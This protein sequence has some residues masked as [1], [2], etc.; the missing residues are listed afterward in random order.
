[1]KAMKYT[2]INWHK[3]EKELL[4]L[5]LKI[6]AAYN[7]GDHHRV[8][9]LQETLVRTF[10]ARALAVRRVTT[11]SGGKTPGV[12]GIILK[13]AESK[14]Q[15]IRDIYDWDDYV[16]SPVKQVI[17]PKANGGERAL[18]I[19]T[20]KD[21]VAQCL[22]MF[23]LQ[24]IAE[25]SADVQSYGFR[26]GRSTQD[27]QERLNNILNNKNSPAYVLDA[28]IKGFFD[29]ID[30][31]W[32]LQHIPMNKVILNKWLKAGIL[33]KSGLIKNDGGVPQGGIISPIIANMVLDGLQ[34][35]IEE[36]VKDLN[37]IMKNK[38]NWARVKAKKAG[39]PYVTEPTRTKINYVRYA[40]DFIITAG[41]PQYY[42]IVMPKVSEFLKER[43]LELNKSKTKIFNVKK[44]GFDFLGFHMQMRPSY[45]KSWGNKLE[46]TCTKRGLN[47]IYLKIRTAMKKYNE[48]AALAKHLNPVL[49]GW[50]NYYKYVKSA[51]V[52]RTIQY[53]I[54]W[55]FTR[56]LRIKY[57]SK[58]RQHR[59]QYIHKS[60]GPGYVIKYGDASLFSIASIKI[61]LHTP[62]KLTAIPFLP[63][64]TEYFKKRKI[65]K[66]NFVLPEAYGR[67]LKKQSYICP[68]CN[69]IFDG[70][71]AIEIHHIHPKHLGG[72]DK[73]TNL[74]LLHKTCHESV[75]YTE[76]P[77]LKAEYAAKGII[78]IPDSAK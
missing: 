49:R 16:V 21:R 60:K 51:E 54:Y 38:T 14:M 76:D 1:M 40:D 28:D 70:S 9:L 47:N 66:I 18:G 72:S 43:G 10:Y 65:S 22:Y 52:F 33:S 61:C 3:C 71:E 56:W 63:E 55:T 39:I 67:L 20:V 41:D 73:R 77:K 15:M 6:I 46:T 8:T 4:K 31:E 29:H 5:Q 44:T 74:L 24:P 69:S 2:N 32:L 62:L 36:S 37:R 48:F 75:T 53:Y 57:G 26:I 35:V 30:H 64:W 23:A 25:V 17:I 68:V 34:A 45:L 78:V 58:W 59:H 11:N 42:E 19:P 12:D 50:G 7:I 27:A 13:T